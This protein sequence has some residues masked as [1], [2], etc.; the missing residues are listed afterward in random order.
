M[1]IISIDFPTEEINE[2]DIIYSNSYSR[3][4]KSLLSPDLYNK[5][6][7]IKNENILFNFDKKLL[8]KE[9]TNYNFETFIHLEESLVIDKKLF[10]IINKNTFFS[11]VELLNSKHVNFAIVLT[12]V[13]TYPKIQFIYIISKYFKYVTMCMSRFCNFGILFCEEKLKYI[14]CELKENP[15]VKD[16]NIKVPEYILNQIKNYNDYFFKKTIEINDKLNTLCKSIN[17]I[18]LLNNEINLINEYY[19][20]YINK[21]STNSCNIC[22]FSHS[23]FLECFICEKCYSLFIP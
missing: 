11:I 22:K 23:T 14:D 2:F 3:P 20:N 10:N 6:K 18:Q 13:Y 4:S 17:N 7:S 16:F 8:I 9:C 12:D 21:H 19:K 1:A 5:Y 15:N